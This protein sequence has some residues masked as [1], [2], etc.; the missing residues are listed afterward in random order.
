MEKG[1]NGTGLPSLSASLTADNQ[2]TSEARLLMTHVISLGDLAG[3]TV[4]S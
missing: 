1:K 2:L 4:E 3:V